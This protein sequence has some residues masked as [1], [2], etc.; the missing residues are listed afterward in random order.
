MKQDLQRLFLGMLFWILGILLAFGVSSYQTNKLGFILKHQELTLLNLFNIFFK[1]LINNL[2][3]GFLISIGGLLSSGLISI[4]VFLFN[5]FMLGLVIIQALENNFTISFILLKLIFHGFFEILGF[6]YFGLAGLQGFDIIKV[7]YK[8]GLL[9][10]NY[11]KL[12]HY[13]IIGIFLILLAATIE[14]FIFFI[15]GS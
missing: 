1:I 7:F 11:N 3:I 5:G 15:H 8:Q 4:I 14:T 9:S 13:H 2:Y 6:L 12:Y 10:M